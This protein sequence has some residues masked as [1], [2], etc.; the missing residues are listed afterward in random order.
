MS[1]AARSCWALQQDCSAAAWRLP[2]PSSCAAEQ[3]HLAEWA[4]CHPRPAQAASA[5]GGAPAHPP[6]TAPPRRS[7]Q[8]CCCGCRQAREVKDAVQHVPAWREWTGSRHVREAALWRSVSALSAP[9]DVNGQGPAAPKNNETPRALGMT[10]EMCSSGVPCS[11]TWPS[12]SRRTAASQRRPE[13][14]APL[15]HA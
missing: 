2:L 5:P 7:A 6:E 13:T 14:A 3:A 1:H 8:S 10:H 9:A 4:P 12:A 11:W 15:Q